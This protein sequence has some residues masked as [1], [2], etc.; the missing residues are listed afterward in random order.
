[1]LAG[2]GNVQ[3]GGYS[4]ATDEANTLNGVNPELAF[5]TVVRTGVGSID[6][7]SGGDFTLRPTVAQDPGAGDAASVAP[8]VVYTGGAPASYDG[9]QNGSVSLYVPQAGNNVLPLP[10]MIVTGAVNPEDAGDLGIHVLGNIDGVVSVVDSDGSRTGTAG[11]FIG[12]FWIPW[13]ETGNVAG[14]SSSIN[15]GAFDQGLLSVGGNVSVSA[16]GDIRDLAV[17]L[18]TTWYAEPGNPMVTTVGGGNLRVSAG[19]D[20]LSGDYFVARGQGSIEAGGLIGADSDSAVPG[21][22]FITGPTNNS[23]SFQSAV[24]AP[25]LALQDAQLQVHARQGADIGGVYDPSYLFY[26]SVANLNVDSQGYSVDSALTVLSTSGDVLL[27]TFRLT[28]EMFGRRGPTQSEI[29]T[30]ANVLPATLDLA[31]LDGGIGIQGMGALYPSP[32][33]QLSLI[34]DQSVSI[35]DND[36]QGGGGGGDVNFS[37]VDA[38]PAAM[39]SPL[40]PLTAN[41][42]P[43]FGS[44]ASGSLGDS[45]FFLHQQYLATKLVDGVQ[46]TVAEP[47]HAEDSQPVRIYSLEGSIVDGQVQPSGFYVQGLEIAVGKPALIQAGQ[48][49]VNLYFAGQNLADADVTRILAGRDIYDTPL[50]TVAPNITLP[51]VVSLQ[52]AGPGTFDVEAGRNIGPLTS[53]NEAALKGYLIANSPTTG[54]DTVGNLYNLYLPH[55]SASV[56]VLFGIGP[57]IDVADFIARYIAPGASVS[58]V[59]SYTQALVTFMEQYEAG[60]GWDTGL[61]KDQKTITLTPEQAWTAFQA[62]PGYMQQLFAEQV[63]ARIFTILTAPTSRNTPAA[64]TPSTLCSRRLTAIPPTASAAGPTART[65]WCTPATWMCAVPPSRPSRAATSPCSAPAAGSCWPAPRRR[66]SWWMEAARFSTRPIRKAC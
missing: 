20:I 66:R 35:F 49:I 37:M 48:D 27:D 63:F 9:G 40:M 23:T 1:V 39:P 56:N 52:L 13:M 42:L 22:S 55:Q 44:N 53:Q 60:Q 51:T 11:Q 8:G 14:V 15:F 43:T 26:G 58:G 32:Y 12:Q 45:R 47:L 4:V 41:N 38:A 34:A 16:A 64:T 65:P 62:L 24:P 18:P 17:S 19:G 5:P 10:E 31:A 30:G 7:A 54:I 25:L 59:P 57:G 21:I 2:G 50:P 6:I 29:L 61:L 3:M 46:V 36:I 28:N 33:G